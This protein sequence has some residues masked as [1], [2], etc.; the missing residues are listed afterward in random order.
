MRWRSYCACAL[1]ASASAFSRSAAEEAFCCASSLARAR[2]CCARSRCASSWATCALS[3]AS[4]TL[5]SGVP[6]STSCP[7]R[8]GI[9]TMR[10]STSGRRSID[11]TASIWPVAAISSRTV[12]T[13]ATATSTGIPMGAPP[14]KPAAPLAFP[15]LH[16]PTATTTPAGLLHPVVLPRHL[17]LLAGEVRGG[18]GRR[19]AFIRCDYVAPHRPLGG[20]ARCPENVPGHARLT[21]QSLPLEVVPQRERGGQGELRELGARRV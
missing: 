4:S 11:W 12:S 19:E 13:R 5:K 3:W 6:C 16:P 2:A 21:D 20:I 9:S 17:H 15:F 7:S 1:R 10:P 18:S 8:T 14:P